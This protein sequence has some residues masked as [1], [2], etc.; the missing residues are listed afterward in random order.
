[1]KESVTLTAE[2]RSET[3]KSAARSMRRTGYLPAVVYGHG[4]ES[5]AL[6]LKTDEVQQLLGRISVATTMIDLHVVGEDPQRVLIREVQRHPYRDD[7]LHLDFFHVRADEA[8]SI[9]V[10]VQL[11]GKPVGVEAGGIL[12]QI[13]YEIEIECLPDEI[14]EA[15]TVD[16]SALDVGDSIH[17]ADVDTG[18]VDVL[19]EPDL[20]ICTVVPPTV[21]KVEEE[22]PEEVEVI[23]G[24]EP[25]EE[26]EAEARAEGKD[27][28]KRRDEDEG[29]E[30]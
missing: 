3:G 30:S 25:E 13:R 18:G 4:E 29:D 9:E 17:I 15:F 6:R 21:L 1:M 22:V 12:Q 26:A 8:I 14:P 2:K 28:A 24:A 16:V 19:D 23:E 20:T 5:H 10:P 7:I 27:K 11:E